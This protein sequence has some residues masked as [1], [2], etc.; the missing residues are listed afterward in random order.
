MNRNAARS[1]A[2][3]ASY[4]DVLQ[5]ARRAE[6]PE[7]RIGHACCHYF[8][9]VSCIETVVQGNCSPK[10]AEMLGDFVRNLFSGIV[11]VSCGE[12]IEQSDTCE[13]LPEP[14][15]K[16]RDDQTVR[17]FALPLIELWNSL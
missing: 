17:T 16:Q 9:L 4:I 5:R 8:Q 3:L 6:P 12:W 1:N 13:S 7:L 11:D 14:P 15:P 2:C 10:S